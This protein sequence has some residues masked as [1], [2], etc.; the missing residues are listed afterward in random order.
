MAVV[1]SNA[2][3]LVGFKNLGTSS[4]G[5]DHVIATVEPDD[6]GPYEGW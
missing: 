1:P 4:P 3:G 6:S 2:P 5:L